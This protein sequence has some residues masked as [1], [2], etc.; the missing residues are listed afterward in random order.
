M[1]F[2]PLPIRFRIRDLTN[3][4]GS[5]RFGSQIVQAITAWFSEPPVDAFD[6]L[7]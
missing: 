7:F 5:D 4:I 1:L 3:L 6:S 2:S